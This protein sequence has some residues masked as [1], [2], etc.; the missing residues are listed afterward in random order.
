MSTVLSAEERKLL[1][2]WL[3]A[4]VLIF[5]HF[6]RRFDERVAEFNRRHSTMSTFLGGR[7]GFDDPMKREKELL[8][9]ANKQLYDTCVI[10]ELG[11][12]KL[13]GDFKE[14]NNNIMGFVVNQ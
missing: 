6:S 11:N 7:F 4:D 1:S 9:E 5:Q 13:T 10:Q 14:F 2:G 8:G 3:G 12:E